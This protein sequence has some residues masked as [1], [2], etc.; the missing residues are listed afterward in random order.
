MGTSDPIPEIAAETSAGRAQ[1]AVTALL[2]AAGIDSPALDARLL[3]QAATGRTREQLVIDPDF[4]L[5]QEQ[6]AT[7]S[8]FAARR[9]AREPVSRILGERA[10]WGRNFEVTSDT[11]DPR[12][13]TETLVEFV[14]DLMCEEART[15]GPLRVLDIGT[16][17]GC[18]LVTLLAELPAARGTGV[19]L[20]T[21]A[22]AV[23]ARNAAR[24][25]VGGR[26]A[27]WE[28]NVL[29][30]VAGPFDI[31]VSNPP[32]IPSAEILALEPEVRTFDP[33]L[34]LDGG[35]DGLDY[36][37]RIVAAVRKVTA[38]GGWCVVEVGAGQAAAV[39]EQIE[40]QSGGA[41]VSTIRTRADLGGHTRCVAWKPHSST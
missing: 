17:T 8:R 34:A 36:Y 35:S 5:S 14:L 41:G 15:R 21:A 28:V 3:L 9:L 1:R 22:L 29:D 19:D 4:P 24:H 32:Y 26:A 18:I 37:R 31:I 30:G 40:K 38:P 23:A 25:R 39:V 11:L 2:A 33:R 6:S 27:W 16:G 7:L 10:F 13:D 12:Q 20:S